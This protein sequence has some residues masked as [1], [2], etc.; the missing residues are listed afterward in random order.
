MQKKNI[1]LLTFV[2]LFSN[3]YA[4]ED[5][6]DIKLH[7]AYD[8]IEDLSE[9]NLIKGYEDNSFRPDNEI[10]NVEVFAIINKLADYKNQS[11]VYLEKDAKWYFE[12]LKKAKAA[13]YIEIDDD[14]KIKAISRVE[15]ASIIAK[16]Y[17]LEDLDYNNNY[18]KDFNKLDIVEKKEVSALVKNNII[19]GYDDNTF[20][21]EE[22]LTRAEFS[23]IISK[24][25]NN[26]KL[27]KKEEKQIEDIDKLN[28]AKNDLLNII[29][30]SKALD[31]SRYSQESIS[32]LNSEI[33]KGEKI[34]DESE[35]IDEIV[36]ITL[37]IEESMRALRYISEDQKLKFIIYDENQEEIDAKI[38]INDEEF[39]NGSKIS[40]GRY[41]VR[42]KAKDM[43]EYQT[44]LIVDNEEKIVKIELK[45]ELNEKY[46]LTLSSGL[47]SE[48]G[49]L[50]NKNERVCV[51]INIPDNMEV[52][53]FIVNGKEKNLL[54]DEY[55]FLIT[56]DTNIK[57]SFK[58]I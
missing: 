53:K 50:F 37:S 9:K 56:E 6:I 13:K 29:K 28:E 40:P 42:I 34:L 27:P 31:L 5:F 25:M 11:E 49:N 51:K 16:V 47:E 14:F 36:K 2:F 19:N 33:F 21:P 41:F 24:A 26:L 48:N 39:I 32:N 45:R 15:M 8:Y 57:V 10:L 17:E 54:S 58:K 46:K 20:R 3:V 52:D 1:I 38:L 55:I 18:F 35:D 44:Y 4:K 22:K 23:K 43:Q 7:W 12:D 30:K